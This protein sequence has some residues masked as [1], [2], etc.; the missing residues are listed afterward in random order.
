MAEELYCI[1]EKKFTLTL[2]DIFKHPHLGMKSL[3]VCR[4]C[5]GM[6]I[7]KEDGKKHAV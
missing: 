5:G 2:S 1:K 4:E 6:A 3:F 7:L